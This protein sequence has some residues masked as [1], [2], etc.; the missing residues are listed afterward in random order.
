MNKNILNSVKINIDIRCQKDLLAIVTLGFE[1]KFEIRYCRITRNKNGLPWL[2]PPSLREQGWKR[3]FVVLK[4]EDWHK[5]SKRVIEKFLKELE[6]K[7]EEGIYSRE[8]FEGLKDYQD[9][10]DISDEDLNKIDKA[11]T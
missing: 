9:K 1:S 2:Q 4:K 8:L 6:L 3:C 5:L 11:I 10:E 7:V